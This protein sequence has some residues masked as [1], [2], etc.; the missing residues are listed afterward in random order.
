MKERVSKVDENEKFLK[1]VSNILKEKSIQ[2]KKL[3]AL[4]FIV[5]LLSISLVSCAPK[6]TE[7]SAIEEPQAP[8]A[9]EQPTE[10]PP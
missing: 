7:A 9:E 2:M 10:V 1:P 8:V 4:M 3:N 5:F 6:A